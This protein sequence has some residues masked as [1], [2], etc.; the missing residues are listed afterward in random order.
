MEKPELMSAREGIQ[1]DTLLYNRTHR[2]AWPDWLSCRTLQVLIDRCGFHHA[3]EILAF[4]PD[5]FNGIHTCGPKMMKEISRLYW[6]QAEIA[7]KA[8]AAVED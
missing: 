2:R 6:E 1:R 5:D 4:E 3:S 7:G 8:W